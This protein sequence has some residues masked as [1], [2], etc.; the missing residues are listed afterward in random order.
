MLSSGLRTFPLELH[1]KVSGGLFKHLWDIDW[2][3]RLRLYWAKLANNFLP[4]S[5][6]IKLFDIGHSRLNPCLINQKGSNIFN[7]RAVVG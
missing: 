1:P 7:I 2:L 5:Y 6:L 3:A 4:W